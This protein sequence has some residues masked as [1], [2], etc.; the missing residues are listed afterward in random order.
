MTYSV[1]TLPDGTKC[2]SGPNCTRHF[3]KQ[4]FSAKTLQQDLNNKLDELDQAADNPWM[5]ATPPEVDNVLAG[6]YGEYYRK[7]DEIAQVENWIASAKQNLDPN[8]RYFRQSD[9]ARNEENLKKYED[10]KAKLEGEAQ[11]ILNEAEPLEKEYIRRGR[12]TRAFLVDNTN[13]HVHRNRSCSTCFPTT[14]YTWLPDYSGADENKIVEDA[15]EKA[16]TVCYPSAPVDVLNRPSKIEAPERKAARE[17][18]EAARAAREAKAAQT[19]ILTKDGQP[20]KLKTYYGVVKS[21]RT[22]EIEAVDNFGYAYAY[23]KFIEAEQNGTSYATD[24]YLPDISRLKEYADDFHLIIESLA[25][26][27]DRPYDEQEALIKA[28]A[29]KKFKRKWN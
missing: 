22:A 11:E 8:Y 2:Y 1:I 25:N 14:R 17:A 3:G 7:Q 12:W 24:E 4:G 18:R 19:G 23:Q 5:T 21:A 26:K 16:C 13:G 28:K 29:E 15:G 20:L 6:I 9:V 27:Y 10:K